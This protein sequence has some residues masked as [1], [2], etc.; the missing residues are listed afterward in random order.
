MLSVCAKAKYAK[1]LLLLVLRFSEMPDKPFP[2]QQNHAKF[3]TA[4]SD[5]ST[6]LSKRMDEIE[7]GG[8]DIKQPHLCNS[9]FTVI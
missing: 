5:L 3:N 6:L 7:E 2:I 1:L 9:E 4:R 8:S